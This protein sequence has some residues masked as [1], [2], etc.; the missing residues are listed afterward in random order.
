MHNSKVT[1]F[2]SAIENLS[3]QKVVRRANL[4]LLCSLNTNFSQSQTLTH[5]S[6]AARESDF[7]VFE[8]SPQAM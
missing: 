1:L 3:D 7:K 6:L 4:P 8:S 2:A 5:E